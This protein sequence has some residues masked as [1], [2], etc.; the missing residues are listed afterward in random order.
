MRALAGLGNP[1]DSYSRHR[2]NAGWRVLD[3]LL[4]RSHVRLLEERSLDWVELRRVEVVGGRSAAGGREDLWLM[5]SKTYM[6]ESGLAVSEG[7]EALKLGPA[8]LLVAYD[9]IDLP[10]GKLRLRPAGGAGGQKGMCS[11]I[12]ALGSERI[13]RLR[14]GVRGE[15]VPADTAEYV[16]SPF[17]ANERELA[18][19]MIERGADA[20]E[21]VLNAGLTATMN[22]SN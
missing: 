9:D 12:E 21:M 14:L 16:L 11:V 8:E 10:L 7:A 18:A 1:G 4:R 2:H 20:V 3:A 15:N 17:E 5:R 19:E 13:P 22:A 6:N